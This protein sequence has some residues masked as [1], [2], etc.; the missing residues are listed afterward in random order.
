ME[1]FTWFN[2]LIVSWI[3]SYFPPERSRKILGRFNGISACMIK[4][5]ERV[6][7]LLEKTKGVK[8]I[9]RLATQVCPLCEDQV[10]SLRLR[11]INY[12][13]KGTL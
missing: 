5:I 12:E 10:N 1:I 2:Q 3:Q 11:S 7:L 4:G 9:K 8:L 13:V 6:T